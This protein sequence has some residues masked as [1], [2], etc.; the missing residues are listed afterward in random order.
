MPQKTAGLAGG[1]ERTHAVG[2]QQGLGDVGHGLAGVHRG[3]LDAP[4]RFGFTEPHASHEETLG[5]VHEL[6]RLEFPLERLVL[7]PDG[8]ELVPR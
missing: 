6:A 3:L 4:E 1:A 2:E 7:V 5:A 8:F